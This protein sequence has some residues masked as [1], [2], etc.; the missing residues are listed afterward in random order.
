M[1]SHDVKNIKDIKNK[2][3]ITNIIIWIRAFI[4]FWE[5]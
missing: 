2:G 4:F 3:Q 5:K 1:M